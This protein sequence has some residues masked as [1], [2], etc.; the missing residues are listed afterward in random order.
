MIFIQAFKHRKLPNTRKLFNISRMRCL[1]HL[2]KRC[3]ESGRQ[4]I[5]ALALYER[6]SI[7]IWN[8]CTSLLGH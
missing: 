8:I 2:C 6:G 5:I 7:R 1:L 3:E 4:S